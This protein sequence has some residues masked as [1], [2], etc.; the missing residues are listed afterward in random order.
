[1]NLLTHIIISVLLMFT[2]LTVPF[3]KNANKTEKIV[4]TIIAVGFGFVAALGIY[5]LTK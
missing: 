4:C 2:H 1:M 3:T 5:K